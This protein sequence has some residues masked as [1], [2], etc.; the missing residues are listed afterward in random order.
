MEA[1]FDG[2]DGLSAHPYAEFEILAAV[3]KNSGT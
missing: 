1:G 2:E 3:M